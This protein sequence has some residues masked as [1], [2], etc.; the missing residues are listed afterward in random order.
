MSD[1]PKLPKARS[2]KRL[3]FRAPINLATLSRT[4]QSDGGNR[5]NIPPLRPVT[6]V[7]DI[8]IPLRR[9]GVRLTTFGLQI[10]SSG[11]E[12]SSPPILEMVDKNKS[13]NKTFICHMTAQ[14]TT[15][16]QSSTAGSRT[17]VQKR[18]P[19]QMDYEIQ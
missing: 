11:V 13:G 3:Y 19:A 15:A 4:V 14:S 1:D 18:T 8:Q 17:K 16:W 5:D 6:S 12:E 10:D 7:N 9:R 2:T